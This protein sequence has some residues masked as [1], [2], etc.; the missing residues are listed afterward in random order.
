VESDNVTAWLFVYVEAP[1]ESVGTETWIVYADERMPE[2]T[3]PALVP[4]ALT[5][6]LADK[7]NGVE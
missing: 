7:V 6:A 5:V 1:G 3:N 4:M 2:L